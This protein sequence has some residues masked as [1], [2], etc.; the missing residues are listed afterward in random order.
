MNNISALNTYNVRSNN[1]ICM[2]KSSQKLAS[3]Y[4]I[5]T[6]ADD[7]AGLSISE[8]MRWQI[9]G[10]NQSVRNI[11]DGISFINVA[12]GALN[13]V[14][15]MIQRQREL[16]VQ[17]ANDTNTQQDR[18]AIQEELDQLADEIERVF[19]DT[20]FNGRNIYKAQEVVTR[21]YDSNSSE[22][23]KQPVVNENNAGK[24]GTYVN[25][26]VTS[27]SVIEQSFAP[28]EYGREN[29]KTT[30]SRIDTT[31]KT[32]RNTATTEV[33][34]SKAIQSHII[35][36]RPEY[37]MIQSGAKKR[38]ALAI[39]L[40]NL[41]SEKLNLNKL[42][43]SDNDKAAGSLGTLDNSI[44]RVNEI[45]SYYGALGNRL[46]HE[47]ANNMNTGE[48]TENAESKLRDTDYA[49][50]MVRYAKQSILDNSTTAM[51]S[52]TFQYDKN[53]LQLI[54]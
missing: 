21:E 49:K 31:T 36:H 34:V 27:Y 30:N 12:D 26:P 8:K 47:T 14:T 10:L 33:T 45:R 2:Q 22:E 35:E 23:I 28:D 16:I 32:Q 13:E 39:R 43:V 11:Q 44:R 40:Y 54:M 7:A 19:A 48:N 25:G 52:N 9:R 20:T 18:N 29:Y 1:N 6:A 46:E 51:L 53:I 24:E 37:I 15:D 41:S 4:R 17:G 3:G 5:N 50:E 42:D 38:N